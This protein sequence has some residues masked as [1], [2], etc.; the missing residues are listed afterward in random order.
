MHMALPVQ[1]PVMADT[2]Y[3]P[4]KRNPSN[5]FCYGRDGAKLSW[6]IQP[7]AQVCAYPGKVVYPYVSTTYIWCVLDPILRTLKLYRQHRQMPAEH[8]SISQRL[9]WVKFWS[10]LIALHPVL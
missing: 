1:E 3:E 9:T 8:L 7:A 5:Y 4:S 2:Q 10:Q 6:D